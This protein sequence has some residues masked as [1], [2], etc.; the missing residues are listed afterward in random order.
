[1]FKDRVE[2]GRLLAKALSGYKD[3]PGGVVVALPRGGAVIGA[4]VSR[5]LGLPLELFIVRKIGYPGNPECA[6]AA[7]AET[8]ILHRTEDSL[9]MASITPAYLAQCQADAREEIKRRQVLYRHGEPFPAVTGRTVILVDDGLATGATFEAAARALQELSPARLIGAVPVAPPATID[10]L[11]SM[12]TNLLVL[13][14]PES[15]LSVGEAY[16]DFQQVTDEKV[17]QI[18]DDAASHR[19]E[20]DVGSL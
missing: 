12:L 17:R 5:A 7:L 3:L 20:R 9:H 18:L 15:F 13:E 11:S 1:M 4:E 14:V 8:G 19:F 16:Q 6:C 2:A 10:R